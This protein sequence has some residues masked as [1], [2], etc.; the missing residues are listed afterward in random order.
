MA[1]DTGLA[2]RIEEIVEP[3]PGRA[4]KAMFGGVVYLANG[5]IAYGIWHDRLIVR[6]GPSDYAACLAR[7]NVA[8]FDVTGRPM[9]GWVTVAPEGFA[10]DDSLAW[11]LQL[12]WAFASALPPKAVGA[13]RRAKR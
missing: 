10:E 8:P 13:R 1:Y 4:R 9:S 6:C 3:F 5:N 2:H 12:G 7:P 11:W